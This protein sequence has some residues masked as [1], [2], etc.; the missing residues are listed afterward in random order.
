MC[1]IAFFKLTCP[2]CRHEF[3]WCNGGDV[4]V[5]MSQIMPTCPKCRFKAIAGAFKP[6]LYDGSAKKET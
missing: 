2:I 3:L 1:A 5:S 4:I 6:V